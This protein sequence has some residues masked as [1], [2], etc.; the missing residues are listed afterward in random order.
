MKIEEILKLEKLSQNSSIIF[1][2]VI[3][4]QKFWVKT[5]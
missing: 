3:K 5:N 4:S 1:E 2:G